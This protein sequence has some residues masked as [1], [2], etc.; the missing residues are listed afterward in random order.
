MK[1]KTEIKPTKEINSK[2]VAAMKEGYSQ[3][4]AVSIAQLKTTKKK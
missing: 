3:R 2:I 1:N 4:K